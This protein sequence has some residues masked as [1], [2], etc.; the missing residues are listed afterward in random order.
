MQ[1]GG[2]WNNTVH[3]FFL[4]V[5]RRSDEH[6]H[7]HHSRITHLNPHLGGANRRIEDGKDVADA[8]SKSLLGLGVEAD[9]CCFANMYFGKIILVDIAENPYVTQ[10]GDRELLARA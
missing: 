5:E 10:V 9:F 2:G 3:F 7:T 6:A 8:A 1:N 4:S